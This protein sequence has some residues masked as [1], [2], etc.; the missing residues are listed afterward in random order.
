MGY[1]GTNFFSFVSSQR[2]WFQ[3]NRI[4]RKVDW[5][6]KNASSNENILSKLQ[7]QGKI[8]LKTVSNFK[9]TTRSDRANFDKELAKRDAIIVEQTKIIEDLKKSSVSINR[10]VNEQA[11]SIVELQ[12]DVQKKTLLI[13]ENAGN[14]TNLEAKTLG[15]FEHITNNCSQKYIEAFDK[16]SYIN[17][18]ISVELSY[19]SF[20]LADGIILTTKG[21]NRYDGQAVILPVKGITKYKIDSWLQTTSMTIGWTEHTQTNAGFIYMGAGTPKFDKSFGLYSSSGSYYGISG[22]GEKSWF[23][24]EKDPNFQFREAFKIVDDANG[25]N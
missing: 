10:E 20:N 11:E 17:G 16:V 21:N 9:K 2:Q 19:N 22:N 24:T 8:F 5:I 4:N 25:I 13:L 14:I 3:N 6:L 7:N 15:A 12:D 18:K 1:F 23:D